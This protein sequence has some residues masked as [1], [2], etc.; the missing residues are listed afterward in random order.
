VHGTSSLKPLWVLL[1][2]YP[3]ADSAFA[4]LHW[5]LRLAATVKIQC[6]P[7]PPNNDFPTLLMLLLLHA[8]LQADTYHIA[9]LD[10][11]R[12]HLLLLRC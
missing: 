11:M 9:A 10:N 3:S 7:R 6:I 12:N 5:D 1:P 8:A 4:A 2:V